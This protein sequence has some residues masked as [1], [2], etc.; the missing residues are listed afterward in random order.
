MPAMLGPEQAKHDS[1]I[2][3]HETGVSQHF[4]RT[5]SVS[6]VVKGEVNISDSPKRALT[7]RDPP[8][9]GVRDLTAIFDPSLI[10]PDSSREAA[11][12]PRKI[13]EIPYLTRTRSGT[14]LQGDAF[15]VRSPGGALALNTP[16]QGVRGRRNGLDPSRYP[17]SVPTEILTTPFWRKPN[18][19]GVANPRGN[20]GKGAL[21][22]RMAGPCF[23]AFQKQIQRA[24]ESIV[25]EQKEKD[26]KDQ[27]AKE[28]EATSAHLQQ[29]GGRG[30]EGGEEGEGGGE[31]EFH[32]QRLEEFLNL[33]RTRGDVNRAH[34]QQAQSSEQKTPGSTDRSRSDDTPRSQR[35]T[36]RMLDSDDVAAKKLFQG[37]NVKQDSSNQEPAANVK[38]QKSKRRPPSINM[39]SCAHPSASKMIYFYPPTQT[40]VL[41]NRC[42][43]AKH[44]H[45]SA[46]SRQKS[47]K[48]IEVDEEGNI[49]HA[50]KAG[51]RRER[52]AKEQ[53]QR[54]E[55][56]EWERRVREY[57]EQQRLREGVQGQMGPGGSTGVSL[58][59]ASV[60]TSHA[61]YC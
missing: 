28:K 14:P 15:H 60:A 47:V 10:K 61:V 59:R 29:R 3:L 40:V 7:A 51:Q 2:E 43:L 21:L 36:P 33:L 9:L 52:E 49:V 17:S 41:D 54:R 44:Q 22:P 25:S 4:D 39:E 55:S 37:E 32:G 35:S 8:K 24:Q 48:I 26:T 34:S 12:T 1:N 57:R 45:E 50:T 18:C 53:R 38:K 30:G 58:R 5:A 42:P 19:D 31:K 56:E 27:E 16:T 11:P 23:D 13:P 6:Y 46:L 20:E